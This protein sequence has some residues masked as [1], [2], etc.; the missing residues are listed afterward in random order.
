MRR[1][2]GATECFGGLRPS[3]SAHVRFHGKPGQV[4]RPGFPVRGSSMA[5]CAAFFEESRMR[6]TNANKLDRKSGGTWGTRPVSIEFSCVDQGFGNASEAAC[7]KA[8][9]SLLASPLVPGRCTMR[10]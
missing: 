7:W 10:M 5:S 3:C 8:W 2:G 6:F 1:V 4:G 9:R